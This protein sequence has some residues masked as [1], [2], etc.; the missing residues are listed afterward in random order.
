M[1]L[2]NTIKKSFIAIN[3]IFLVWLGLSFL[4]IVI[5]NLD[6]PVYNPFNL[7]VLFMGL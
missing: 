1:K 3:T 5:K 4:E 2:L 6:N 7:F